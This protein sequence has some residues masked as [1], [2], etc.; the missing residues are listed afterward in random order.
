ME[1]L[2]VCLSACLSVT[3][4]YYGQTVGWIKMKLGTKVGLGPGD[5]MVDVD[6]APL[7]KQGAQQPPLFGPCLFWR[8]GS[9]D[10][11]P[12]WYGDSAYG[13]EMVQVTPLRRTVASSPYSECASPSVL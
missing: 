6:S 5:I 8:N 1:P 11:D 9:I 7:P 10:Q 12:M 13:T 3:L 2:S 4:V